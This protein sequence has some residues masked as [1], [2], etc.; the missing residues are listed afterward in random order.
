M[1]TTYPF[2]VGVLASLARA[3]KICS[4]EATDDKRQDKLEE[5]QYGEGNIC[6]GH[7]E[8]THIVESDS[9][10]RMLFTESDC[11]S[12]RRCRFYCRTGSN[13]GGIVRLVVDGRQRMSEMETG[14]GVAHSLVFFLS[15]V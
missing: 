5:V 12:G 3:V 11:L 14:K 9:R 8:E 2:A 10:T 7:S 1:T 15:L 4:V 13:E 6:Q